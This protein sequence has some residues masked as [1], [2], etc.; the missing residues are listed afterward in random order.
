MPIFSHGDVVET[1]NIENG[2]A[3]K[4]RPKQ[5][6]NEL[7]RT[8]KRSPA[9]QDA[10]AINS[11]HNYRTRLF[12]LA[13]GEKDKLKSKEARRRQRLNQIHEPIIEEMLSSVKTKRISKKRLNQISNN[14]KKSRFD[15]NFKTQY[16]TYHREYE[17]KSGDPTRGS[18]V[19]IVFKDEDDERTDIL[20]QMDKN[21][22]GMP[23]GGW[24]FVIGGADS[25]EETDEQTGIRETFEETGIPKE[26]GIIKPTGSNNHINVD[27]NYYVAVFVKTVPYNTPHKPGKEIYIN[28]GIPCQERFT[29]EEFMKLRNVRDFLLRKHDVGFEMALI[30]NLI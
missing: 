16:K 23:K 4:Q 5:N 20:L 19:I 10:R 18:M 14:R 17:N 21:D 12:H 9:A 2:G 24:G 7:I 30:N 1:T 15:P 29:K 25:K 27:K 28:N 11:R 26:V 8:L 6:V 13:P 3:V 22:D